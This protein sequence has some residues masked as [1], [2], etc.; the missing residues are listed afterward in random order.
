MENAGAIF[1]AESSITGTRKSE[2]L[3]AHEIAHQWFGD[4]ATETDWPHLWLSEGFA[5]EMTHLYLESKYGKDTLIK[6]LQ[7]DRASVLAFTKKTKLAVVDTVSKNL[8]QLLNTNSYQKGGWILQMLRTELG[9]IIFWKS[10]QQYYAAYRG[11]NASTKDLQKTFEQVSGKDLQTFFVQ[12]LYIGEN[13]TLQVNWSYEEK[14]K[15]VSVQVT[16]QT[17]RIFEF[18]LEIRLA[19]ETRAVSISKKTSEFS[20]TAKNRPPKIELDPDC[21]L[22]FEGS[23]QEV[24]K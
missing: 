20:F 8:M 7:R 14:N 9:D 24:A 16:Q 3:L 2:G 6:D 1:Y 18:P 21:K 5:T 11:K 10:V 23:L 13:P 4:A 17:E 15:R 19:G 12:W 22:L